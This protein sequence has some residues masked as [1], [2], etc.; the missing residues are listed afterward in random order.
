MGRVQA[1]HAS[2]WVKFS[3]SGGE[4]GR[5]VGVKECL[6]TGT[7]TVKDGSTSAARGEERATGGT[8]YKGLR[9]GETIYSEVL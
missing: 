5:D 7:V 3:L 2:R 1:G 6:R 9:V 8:L 4:A